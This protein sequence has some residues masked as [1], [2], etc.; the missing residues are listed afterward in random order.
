LEVVQLP[1]GVSKLDSALPN[2]EMGDFSPHREIM[3]VVRA[4]EELVVN[5]GDGLS[6]LAHDP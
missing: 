6:L 3:V 4:G 2:V 5:L 1:G